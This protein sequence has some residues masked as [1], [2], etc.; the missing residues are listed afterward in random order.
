MVELDCVMAEGRRKYR[1]AFT[2]DAAAEEEQET[3]DGW[4]IEKRRKMNV[5]ACVKD[6]RMSSKSN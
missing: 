1:S 2:Q 5:N 6:E 4:M 3:K